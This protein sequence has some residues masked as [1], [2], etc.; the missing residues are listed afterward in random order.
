MIINISAGEGNIPGSKSL[1][2]GIFIKNNG[3]STYF[4]SPV[5]STNNNRYRLNPMKTPEFASNPTSKANG[6][7]LR[8]M[9]QVATPRIASDALLGPGGQ[10]V[11]EHAGRDYKLRITQNG[12]LILTA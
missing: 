3:N 1:F 10:L 11:I 5:D 9:E 6:R 8:D 12:K 4:V 7:P 2:F